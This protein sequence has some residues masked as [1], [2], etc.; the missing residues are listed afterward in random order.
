[1]FRITEDASSESLVQCLAKNYKYGSI[2][3]IDM[4]KVN[5]IAAHRHTHIQLVRICCHNTDLVR[6]IVHHSCNFQPSTVQGSLMMDPLWSETCW[7]TFK[8]FIIL[9][10]FIY[11]ILCISWTIKCLSLLLLS[12]RRTPSHCS[13][14]HSHT[15]WHAATTPHLQ[16]RIEL[17]RP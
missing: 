2:V 11:Y 1:M 13:T 5:V 16:I 3:S 9:I 6:V 10:V 17:W 4:D 14:T 7:S 8:H 12:I 15:T